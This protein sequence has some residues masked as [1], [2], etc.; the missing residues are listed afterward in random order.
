MR[1][2]YLFIGCILFSF[3]I[4]Q[5]FGEGTKQF[6]PTENKKGEL[7]IDTTRN[8]FTSVI[9]TADYRLHIHI[10]DWTNKAI[11][12]GFGQTKHNNG[13]TNFRFYRPD[14]TID[15]SGA[16]PTVTGNRGYIDTWTEA[17]AGPSVISPGTGYWGLRCSPD[18]NGDYYLAFKITWASGGFPP[19]DEFKTFENFD[20]TVVN[21]TTLE[22]IEGRLWSRAWQLYCETPT[23]GSTN[24]Y[25]GEMYAYSNDSIVTKVNFNG[26]IPGTF[27]VSCNQSGCYPVPPST[28][29]VARKL[30]QE[31]IPI[32]NMIFFLMIPMLLHIQAEP[33]AGWII[34]YPSRL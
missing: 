26:M 23:Q 5:G 8:K 29:P 31:N 25:F 22:A 34:Q 4:Q 16:V 19:P 1:T 24:Q 11:Y 28:P 2:F 18:M 15:T 13:A 27:T 12:F 20:V 7:C 32:P 6:R 10:S 33:S 3:Q 30:W 14:G 21:L 17:V 9:A